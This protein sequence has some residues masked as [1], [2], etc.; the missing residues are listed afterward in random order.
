MTPPTPRITI[1]LSTYNGSATL[2]RCFESL[3]NQTEKNFHIVCVNDASTDHTEM[4]LAAWQQKFGQDKMVVIKNNANQGLTQSLNIGLTS[5]ATEFTARIDADDW[6]H[7]AKLAKQIEFFD[8]HAGYGVVGTW[9]ENHGKHGV[10]QMKLPL[11]D[12]EIRKN[13]LKRNPFAHS[14]VMF[15]TDLVKNAGGYDVH[16]RYGQDYE[17]WLRLMP[18]TKFANLDAFLCYRTADDT[19]TARK[20]REQMMLCVKTQLYYLRK[21]HRPW[22]EYRYIFNPLL[23]ALAPD[24][25]RTLKRRFL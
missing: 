5:I 22:H 13:I 20:Q 14:A 6:W 17:L 16:W 7:P 10:K 18:H 9:Y 24:W 23:V 8:T 4:M 25:L 21:Y 12:H 1:L 19:L 3:L 11:T 15:R 2:D